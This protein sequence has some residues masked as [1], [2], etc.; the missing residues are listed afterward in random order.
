MHVCG[1]TGLLLFGGLAL[2]VY[3]ITAITAC[4]C[5]EEK[6]CWCPGSWMRLYTCRCP[7]WLVWVLWNF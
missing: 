6:C 7:C 5:H 4:L 1:I 2:T 3:I